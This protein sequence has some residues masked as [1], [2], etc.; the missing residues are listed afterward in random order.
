MLE[1]DPS[2]RWADVERRSWRFEK[3]LCHS[4]RHAEAKRT[5][6]LARDESRR[7]INVQVKDESVRSRN[8]GERR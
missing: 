6:A 7:W 5:A 1:E 4:S 2:R 3:R 8:T